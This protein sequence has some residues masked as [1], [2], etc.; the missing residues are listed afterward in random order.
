MLIS[1]R[2]NLL[3]VFIIISL[4]FFIG[5]CAMVYY[6]GFISEMNAKEMGFTQSNFFWF[7]YNMDIKA[8]DFQFISNI[9]GIFILISLSII[10]G[11]LSRN[12][13]KKTISPEIFFFSAFLLSF[14]F[15]S[16]R[17]LNVLFKYINAPIYYSMVTSR[18]VYFG[19]ILGLL[20][21]L[22]TSLYAADIKYQRYETLLG[23]S[24]IIALTLSYSIPIDSTVFLTNFLYKLG[25]ESGIF[26][27]FLIVYIIIIINFV[28]ATLN[29]DSKFL[30]AIPYLLLVISGRELINF[31][32]S[33]VPVVLSGLLILIGTLG[34]YRQIDKIYF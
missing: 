13:F 9:A 7:A 24:A 16:F 14:S 32:I 30:A 12:L 28:G 27:I 26:F 5:L 25:D 11:F 4:L 10:C 8:D 31:L 23:L 34:F 17:L 1:V 6:I 33:P 29:K 21:L 3:L 15:E 19:R 2:N 18:I 20:S 22:F